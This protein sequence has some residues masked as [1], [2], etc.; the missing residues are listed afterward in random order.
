MPSQ[1]T[2]KNSFFASVAQAMAD[3]ANNATAQQQ[4]GATLAQAATTQ[5][6][7]TLFAVD[8]A[9]L[10]IASSK[11]LGLREGAKR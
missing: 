4:Q 11:I 3:A 7:A 8:T 1:P 6:V 9:A 5:G 10:G 2:S